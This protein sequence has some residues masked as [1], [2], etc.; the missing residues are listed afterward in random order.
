MSWTYIASAAVGAEARSSL[1]AC[2]ASAPEAHSTLLSAG[3]GAGPLLASAVAW[4]ELGTA[5]REAATEL[6][7]TLATVRAGLWDGP[8]SEQYLA[9]HQPYLGWLEDAATICATTAAQLE[10]AAAAYLS[11]IAEMPTPM[12]LALNHAT[13]GVLVGTNFLGLNTIPIAVNEADYLRM[14]VQAATTMA[15]YAGAADVALASV[16]Q[17]PPAPAILAPGAFSDNAIAAPALAN[18]G[19]FDVVEAILRLL[20][21]APV[22]DVINALKSLNLGQIL[23]L[24]ITNPSAALTALAPLISAL[25]GLVGYV[26]ISL[27][28]FTLQIGSALLLF[29]T[30]IGLPLAIAL[31]DQS[32]LLP[33]ADPAPKPM[34][35]AAPTTTHRAVAASAPLVSSVPSSASAPVTFTPSG[36][37]AASTVAPSSGGP[38]LYAVGWAGP[39]P[40]AYPTVSTGRDIATSQSATTA[41][42]SAPATRTDPSRSKSRRR[43]RQDLGSRGAADHRES[44]ARGFVR[45]VPLIGGVEMPPSRPL[46]PGAWPPADDTP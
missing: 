2:F 22:Y 13:H 42:T 41:S 26:A 18:G 39:E 32:R 46:M 6:Q 44:P 25:A 40:P 35:S 16:P 1:L 21:P 24:L 11:A 27:T 7:H 15:V 34:D 45:V 8:S 14:W 38:V 30:A 31:A 12:E 9:A 19:L 29:G 10:Q 23:A 37:P 5:Y 3:P 4:N 20:V 43:R 28:L 17:L 36:G 33:P